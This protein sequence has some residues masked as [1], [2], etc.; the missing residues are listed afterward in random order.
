MQKSHRWKLP[1]TVNL[2]LQSPQ[3]LCIALQIDHAELNALIDQ[4]SVHPTT[5]DL[6][7]RRLKKQKLILRDRIAQLQQILLPKEP[8]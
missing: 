6:Q 1:M 2:D 3:R 4:L 8:A 5:D 7:I